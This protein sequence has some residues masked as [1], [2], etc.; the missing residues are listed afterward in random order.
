MDQENERETTGPTAQDVARIAGVSSSTV[1]RVLNSVKSDM[2]SEATRQRVFDAARQLGYSPNPIARALRGGQTNLLYLIARE[3]SDPFFA[4][5]IAVIS[6]QARALGYH[7]VLGNAHSD[8]EEALEIS[9]VLDT[10]HCDGVIV[11]GDLK[12]DEAVLP[13]ILAGNHTAVA[14]CRGQSPA[15][16][17]TINVDNSKG[18][19]LLWEHL[20]SLGHQR[21]GFI[22]G[23]WLGD[24]RERRK[25]FENLSMTWPIPGMIQED[26]DGLE[27][28]YRAFQT[29]ISQTPRP[30]AI[31]AA[32][33]TMAIGALQAA[34]D[35]GLRV[36]EDISVVG[37]DDIEMAHF[38][39]PRLTTICQPVE[40]MSRQVLNW[41]LEMIAHKDHPIENHLLSLEPKLVIRESTGPVP[42]DE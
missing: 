41:I 23:G 18:I 11:L 12:D 35:A 26:A 37:F 28:G 25:A 7:I 38:V 10:R 13:K 36:P 30:T 34:Q 3:I 4:N 27:G 2:I 5:F 8:P 6:G 1:S 39:H 14:L 33:D 16:M 42:L 22:D 40:E 31:F 15:W 9:H 29:L 32:D 19:H 20:T 21:F 24:I 17:P